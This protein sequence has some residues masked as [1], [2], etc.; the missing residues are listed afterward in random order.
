MPEIQHGW[1]WQN[2]LALA[3]IYHIPFIKAHPQ[4]SCNFYWD[5]PTK[6]T[7]RS[8][9]I[10]FA[11]LAPNQT[12]IFRPL[13]IMPTTFSTFYFIFLRV[14]YIVPGTLFKL[15]CFHRIPFTTWMTLVKTFISFLSVLCIHSALINNLPLPS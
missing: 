2:L 10:I 1:H 6:H 14:L 15:F 7:F 12:F 9:Y 13:Q 3:L 5:R 8:L 4:H 11:I